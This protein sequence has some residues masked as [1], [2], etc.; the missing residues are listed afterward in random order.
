MMILNGSGLTELT[1]FD[2]NT[3]Y[4]K[5]LDEGKNTNKLFSYVLKV[6]VLSCGNKNSG[7]FEEYDDNKYEYKY[8]SSKDLK[9]HYDSSS[10]L[11]VCDDGDGVSK[12]ECE[13]LLFK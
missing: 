6:P 8:N 1:D 7:C 12:E 4:P 13:N 10:G 5:K 3:G 2:N 11:I 9:F